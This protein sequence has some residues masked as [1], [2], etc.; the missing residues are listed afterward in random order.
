[1]P[2]AAFDQLV[3]AGVLRKRPRGTFY[4]DEAAVIARRRRPN[5]KPVLV[6]LVVAVTTATILLGAFLLSRSP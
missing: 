2:D 1:V 4:L 5:S 6:V 3:S